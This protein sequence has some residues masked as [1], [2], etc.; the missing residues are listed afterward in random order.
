M[1]AQGSALGTW[2]TSI[3][4]PER[5]KELK[6]KII[7]L[8]FQGEIYDCPRTQG[9][10]PPRNGGNEGGVKTIERPGKKEKLQ[11]APHWGKRV[12]FQSFAPV[13]RYLGVEYNTQGVAL[14]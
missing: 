3:L 8:P 14:G 5:A 1:S 13:G 12:R 11:D 7:L 9:F 10:R 2:C 6:Q 4:R